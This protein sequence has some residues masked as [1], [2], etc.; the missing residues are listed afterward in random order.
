MSLFSNKSG[1]V[2]N[3]IL[4][5]DPLASKL[6]KKGRRIVRLNRGDPS[7]YFT[8]PK[9]MIDAYVRALKEGKTYYSRA[10]GVRELADAVALRYRKYSMRLSQ[11]DVIITAGVS[12]AL[13]FLNN[14]LINPGDHAVL[15]SPYYPQ[16]MPRLKVEGG[17][18]VIGSTIMEDG[19]KLDIDDLEKRIRKIKRS[20][21]KARIKYMMVTNPSNPTGKVFER[22]ELEE[23]VEVANEHKLLLVSDEIYDEMIYNGARFTSLGQVADGVPHMIFNG[24]SKNFDSTGFR[25]GFMIIPGRDKVSESLRDK[26]SQYALLRLSLNTPAQYAVAEAMNNKKAHHAAISAMVGEIK[27]RVNFAVDLLS[28]NPYVT[29]TRPRGAFYVFPKLD[30]ES[31][32]F[33]GS[34]DF[35]LKA[36]METGVQLTGGYSFGTPSHFRISALPPKDTLEYAISRVNEFCLKHAKR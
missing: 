11:D 2:Q 20:S 30:M 14:G 29:V 7:R 26:F 23:M 28:E 32:R 12:E 13:L 4:E 34:R 24:S 25:I 15:L 27:K 18:P 1:D 16:Y 5:L 10:Q 35:V 22:K 21:K 33:N 6:E 8:T 17:V 3:L 9:Y 19:W 36:L 31:L